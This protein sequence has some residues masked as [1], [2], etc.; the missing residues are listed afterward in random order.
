MIDLHLDDILNKSTKDSSF[1]VQLQ[2][3]TSNRIPNDLFIGKESLYVSEEGIIS[4]IIEWFRK[5]RE[6]REARRKEQQMRDW[7]N[8]INQTFDG[9]YDWLDSIDPK[10]LAKKEIDAYKYEDI[11]ALVASISKVSQGFIGL[12]PLKYSSMLKLLSNIR[13]ILNGQKQF[14]LDK[15][16]DLIF[17]P[18]V[19]QPTVLF[20]TSKW[21]SEQAVKRLQ[22]IV[23]QMDNFGWKLDDASQRVVNEYNAQVNNADDSQLRDI[24]K[25]VICWLNFTDLISS[26]EINIVKAVCSTLNNM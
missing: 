12:D 8:D 11:Y 6:A 2:P 20:K 21:S 1:C 25:C 5:K 24:R 4:N 9:Y 10:Y 19:S 3:T 15:S 14:Y 22:S 7:Q 16:D 23:I 18:D 17:Q 26:Q 13:S